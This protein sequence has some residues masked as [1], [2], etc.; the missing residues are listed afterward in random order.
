MAVQIIPHRALC[1]ATLLACAFP[2]LAQDELQTRINQAIDRGVQYLKKQ[3]AA[4]NTPLETDPERLGLTVL[5]GWTLL[6]SGVS[7]N[8]LAVQ[9]AAK[10]TREHCLASNFAYTVS[11]SI[12]F[13]DR[14]GETSDRPLIL[15]MGCSLLAAMAEES[16]GWDY[17][18]PPL[19]PTQPADVRALEAAAKA[20]AKEPDEKKRKPI[21]GLGPIVA[22]LRAQGLGGAPGDNSNTQFAMMALWVA[23]RHG[24]PVEA[25]LQAVE[26][27]F[28]GSQY[29][30]GGWGYD[31]VPFDP[32]LDPGNDNPPRPAMTCAA[33]LGVALGNGVKNKEHKDKQLVKDPTV[34]RGLQYL[35]KAFAAFNRDDPNNLYM[36]WSLERMAVVYDLKKIGERDWYGWG[37]EYLVGRQESDGSWHGKWPAPSDTCFALLV[38]KKANVAEDLTL[39][40]QGIIGK[41][42]LKSGIKKDEKIDLPIFVPK[43]KKDKPKQSSSVG[44]RDPELHNSQL[45]DSQLLHVLSARQVVEAAEA[46]KLEK[47]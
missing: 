10:V 17:F 31:Y 12:L 16:A 21:A 20:W 7:T 38:L 3:Q 11:L 40:L 46:E 45:R 24:L 32:N 9:K 34:Q 35:D 28:R 47:T 5:C 4:E 2:A 14:L 27:R 8:D 36:L 29:R 6:E 41:G 1:L 19:V 43:D 15:G 13:L 39:N 23:R 22:R 30:N 33:L 18:C 44:P 37:A 42:P 25:A 26:A